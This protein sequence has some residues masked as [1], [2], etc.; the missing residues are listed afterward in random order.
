VKP[1]PPLH[2]QQ[3]IGIDWGKKSIS[4]NFFMAKI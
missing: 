4:L 1:P 3:P 2:V